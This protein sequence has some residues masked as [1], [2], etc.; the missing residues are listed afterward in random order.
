MNISQA[1]QQAISVGAIAPSTITQL[2]NAV[3]TSQDTRA[4]AVLQDA[5]ADGTVSLLTGRRS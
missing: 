1:V 2:Q 3:V 4:L 5:L